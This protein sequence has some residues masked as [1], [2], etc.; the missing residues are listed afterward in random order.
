MNR[1]QSS[2][3]IIP[4]STCEAMEADRVV[5]KSTKSVEWLEPLESPHFGHTRGLPK[6]SSAFWSSKKIAKG[7]SII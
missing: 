7:N 1:I 3:D 2:K 5:D 4:L 6:V